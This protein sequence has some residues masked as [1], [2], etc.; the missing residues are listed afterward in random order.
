MLSLDECLIKIN[1]GQFCVAPMK[2]CPLMWHCVWL[3]CNIKGC[4]HLTMIFNKRWLSS[5][6]NGL[7]AVNFMVHFSWIR[8]FDVRSL[9]SCKPIA[10]WILCHYWLLFGCFKGNFEN[11]GQMEMFSMPGESDL[12]DSFMFGQGRIQ[13]PSLASLFESVIWNDQMIYRGKVIWCDLLK[14]KIYQVK[15]TVLVSVHILVNKINTYRLKR[16]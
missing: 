1:N 7:V 11:T 9:N 13:I 4:F 8:S 3:I 15:G 12:V 16:R 5:L 10:R 2:L 6:F 14:L